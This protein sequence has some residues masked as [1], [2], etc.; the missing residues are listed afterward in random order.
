[1]RY[2]SLLR[3]INVSGHKKILMADLKALYGSLD[4]ENVISYIQS[5]NVI[6][7]SSIA[8]SVLQKQIEEVIEQHYGFAVPVQLK[9]VDEFETIVNRCPFKELDLVEEGTRVFV[10]F[11]DKVPLSEDIESLMAYVKAPE[12][13]QIER[14]VVYLH[15]P[16]G[17]G[18]TK[19]N[20]TFVEKKLKVNATA[21]NWKSVIKL[22][23]LASG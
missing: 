17:Y 9:T 18:K 23:D 10:I 11:L 3:G 1:M 15:C 5:G 16:N 14:Q 2:I 4:C 20:N 13:L 21:R 12:R 7:D 22:F 19:L 6:F 8:V